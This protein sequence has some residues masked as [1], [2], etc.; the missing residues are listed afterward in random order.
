MV[1]WRLEAA[2]ADT[3]AKLRL[4]LADLNYQSIRV[5]LGRFLEERKA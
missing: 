4:I 2:R 3:Q 5:P 1:E